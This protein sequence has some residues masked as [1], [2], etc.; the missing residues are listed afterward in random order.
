MRDIGRLLAGLCTLATAGAV[1]ASCGIDACPRPTLE[2][3]AAVDP[4]RFSGGFRVV[5]FSTEAASGQ[6]Y[7]TLAA[8]A[9]SP[10][11]PLTIGVVV[12]FVQ[13]VA[14]DQTA[15]G[16]GNLVGTVEGRA[17]LG[18]ALSGA[19]FGHL[20]AQ[21]EAP[22]GSAAIVDDHFEILPYGMLQWQGDAL[23]ARAWVGY[24]QAVVS[25]H[26]HDH[27]HAHD[28][29]PSVGDLYRAG[30]AER[31]VLHRVLAGVS[32]LGGLVEP[33]IGLDGQ[34]A[35]GDG[36]G[37]ILIGRAQVRSQIG[38]RVAVNLA[39]QSALTAARH[40]DWATALRLEVGL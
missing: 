7:E 27:D 26:E 40:F 39:G 14:D 17:A 18:E 33:A 35:L 22:T 23:R 24:R 16:L 13:L 15:S 3:T 8:A 30:H 10:L 12:P 38:E 20:G 2:D 34:H 6:A 36:P 11:E 32:T 4:V 19:L 9:W 29:A 37:A 25:G 5:G 31:E 21:L 1:H 28:H